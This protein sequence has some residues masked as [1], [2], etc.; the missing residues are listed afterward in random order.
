MALKQQ[1]QSDVNAA[2]KAGD[3]TKRTLLGMVLTSI[4]NREI[5][6]M[7]ELTEEEIVDTL[8][9]ELKKRKEAIEQFTA[10]NRPELAQKEQD[11]A[12]IIATYLPPE[13]SE[14]EIESAVEAAIKET[15][16]SSMAEMGKVM[17]T[18]MATLK[19]KADGSAVSA[20]V[21]RMLSRG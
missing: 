4:K 17:S 11:E 15:G 12:D 16:A 14:A 13:L 10:G 9:K 8:R 3:Q 6:K 2:L 21:K 20:V 5:D 7:S 19:G 18:A 1:L